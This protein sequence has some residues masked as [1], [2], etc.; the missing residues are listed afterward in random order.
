MGPSYLVS[1]ASEHGW[2][3]ALQCRSNKPATERLRRLPDAVKNAA[4]K[5]K[6]KLKFAIIDVRPPVSASNVEP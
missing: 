4:T 3:V 2:F 5:T 1:D 6:K